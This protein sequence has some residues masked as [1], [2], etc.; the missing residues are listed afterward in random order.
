MADKDDVLRCPLCQGH[1]ELR[2][3]E[4]DEFLTDPELR[5]VIERYLA[6]VGETAATS[7]KQKA[8]GGRDF[9]KEVHG[10][11]PELPIFRRSPKE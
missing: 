5:G 1:G 10:W 3:S 11:N 6:K 8:N 7:A 9:D 4:L 2:R